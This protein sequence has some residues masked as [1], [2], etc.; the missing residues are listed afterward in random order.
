MP[1]NGSSPIPRWRRVSGRPGSARPR[2][3]TGTERPG[4]PSTSTSRW[5][6]PGL[7]SSD[8]KV[9]LVATVKDAG[10][11]LDAWLASV[12]AQTR[13]PAEVVVVDGG[14]AD[15]TWA[16]LE[17]AEGI[18]AI[19]EPGANIARGRNVAVRAAA[20]DLVAVSD[21]DCVLA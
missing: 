14:S 3:S 1:S 15:D 16:R 21:A 20:H 2:G 4:S 8:M 11:A 9:S 5:R 18:T 12:R 6:R 13:Q 10:P 17:R 7:G 19:S